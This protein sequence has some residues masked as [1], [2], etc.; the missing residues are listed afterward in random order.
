MP[1]GDEFIMPVIKPDA[2]AQMEIHAL[3]QISAALAATNK[4]LETTNR[5]LDRLVSDVRDVRERVIHIEA[6]DVKGEVREA[7][8]EVKAMALRIDALES[9][10]DRQ[11]GAMGV[12]AWMSKH[13]P[14]LVALL[15]AG[16]AGLGLKTGAGS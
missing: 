1:S 3:R 10:R 4:G 8:A 5:S 13:A 9:V 7:K 12:G 2:I 16:L 6:Q 14:W 15:M 11:S